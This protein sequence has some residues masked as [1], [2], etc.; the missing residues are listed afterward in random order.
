MKE[1]VLVAMSGG[2]DSS[3]AAALLTRA[4]YDCAGVT[5]K[6]FHSAT[7]CL[8]AENGCCSLAAAADARAAAGALGIPHY[9]FNFTALFEQ[10]VIKPFVRAYAAGL[11][12]NPCIDCNRRVKFP[13]LWQR[14]REIGASF[15]ATGHYAAV[16]RDGGSG[17][18]LLRKAADR[19]KDQSYVLYALTQ[20]ELAHT[21]F[22]L[23]GLTKKETRRLAAENRLP[24]ANKRESQDIC[25]VPD[26][27]YAAFIEKYSG[28]VSPPGDFIGP[29][30]VR[31]GRHRG[32]VR[33]TVGQRR[34]L[35]IAWREPLYVCAKDAAANTVRLGVAADL[36]RKEL[37]VGEVNFI[38]V[39]RLERPR[40]AEVKLRYSQETFPAVV[41]Q[42]GADTARVVFD[43]PQAAAAPGQAAVF[44]EDDIVI[45]GG[46]IL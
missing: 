13:R 28:A 30:G 4:G 35:G 27:D 15:I 16:S 46:T 25:F 29:D 18:Y 20:E 32:I 43:A 10:Q 21:L 8:P 6:L 34:G 14:A 23:G 22:P 1:K 42:T 41:E 26:G 9:V 17:R 39:E 31:L 40:R 36:R 24:N 12:P 44:Y 37:T 38:A 19:R 11:T 7:A 45:G 33:Y 5:L 2:V 3:A